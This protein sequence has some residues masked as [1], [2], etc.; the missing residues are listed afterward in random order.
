M[1]ENPEIK[2]R[3]VARMEPI[4]YAKEHGEFCPYCR[5]AAVVGTGDSYGQGGVLSAGRRCMEC[6]A[7][8]KDVFFLVGYVPDTVSAHEPPDE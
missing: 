1:P 6:K 5:T 3:K 4:H 2:T 7:H 8:W